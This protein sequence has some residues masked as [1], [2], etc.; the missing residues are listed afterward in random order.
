[1]AAISASS[2]RIAYISFRASERISLSRKRHS[3]ANAELV[4]LCGSRFTVALH[5]LYVLAVWYPPPQ[6]PPHDRHCL[7]LFM[8]RLVQNINSKQ[9]WLK[10]P[11]LTVE[12]VY[13]AQYHPG[14]WV[15]VNVFYIAQQRAA[16]VQHGHLRVPIVAQ[17][18]IF[19]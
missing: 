9:P 12:V 4:C 14:Y 6:I 1:M 13:L 8:A 18:P 15:S 3:S 5:G 10:R 11:R 19:A 7:G 2:P 16:F 17:R